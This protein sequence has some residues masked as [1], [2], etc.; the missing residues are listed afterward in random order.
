MAESSIN[1]GRKYTS[2]KAKAFC[3][4][5]VRLIEPSPLTSRYRHNQ[6][7]VGCWLL[8][9]LH[10]FLY[11]L[12]SLCSSGAFQL[13]LFRIEMADD[14][15]TDEGKVPIDTEQHTDI[16]AEA[17]I[18]R[19]QDD[20]SSLDATKPGGSNFG[21]RKI[22]YVAVS[23]LI[24]LLIAIPLAGSLCLAFHSSNPRRTPVIKPSPADQ[25][26]QS[27]AVQYSLSFPALY[28]QLA[29]TASL[30]CL[31]A[32]YTLGS[33]PC[34]D[35]IFDRSTDNCT[36]RPLGWDPL[37]VLPKVCEARCSTA[38][39]EAW[40]LLAMKCNST[41]DKFELNHYSGRFSP[42]HLETGPLAAV[43]MLLQ[44][45]LHQ[46]RPSPD[47]D[48]D[49]DYCPAELYDRF[50]IVDGINANQN[51]FN[52]IDMFISE[53]NK[54]RT[55]GAYKKTGHRGTNGYSYSYNF[56]V[57]EQNYGPGLGE[58]TC[59]SCMLNYLD[60]SIRAWTR[61]GITNP[62]TGKA[63]PLPEFIR[64][65]KKA[66]ERCSPTAKWDE[67]YQDAVASYQQ[68]DLLSEDWETAAD[69]SRDLAF[70]LLNGPSADDS[71]VRE[72]HAE[73]GRLHSPAFLENWKGSPP[74]SL[75]TLFDNKACLLGLELYY[76]SEKCYMHLTRDELAG[77][78]KTKKRHLR[79]SYC[80]PNCLESVF[81]NEAGLCASKE[82]LPA[83][84]QFHDSYVRA[85]RQRDVFCNALRP[86]SEYSDCAGALRNIGK[87]DWAL[88]GRPHTPALLAEVGNA[89][90]E[91]E[92]K[93]VLEELREALASDAHRLPYDGSVSREAFGLEREWT[94]ELGIGICAVCIWNM[95]AG[96]TF[97]NVLGYLRD[98][99]SASEYLDMV[100]RYHSV[101]TSRGATWL[102]GTPYG[103][104]PFLWR[105]KD[106]YGRVVRYVHGPERGVHRGF[107]FGLIE[108]TGNVTSPGRISG[109][110]GMF[111]G[112]RGR[113]TWS[114]QEEMLRLG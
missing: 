5:N 22:F 41:A 43:R 100:K 20:D 66:G 54:K 26:K 61:G 46:C 88:D 114:V 18:G 17:S 87:T 79:H 92:A 44:R 4:Y 108:A 107:L 85:L 64:R 103:D 12:R 68:A 2:A 50:A 28:P 32:W 59:G 102:G 31:T 10:V 42:D 89:L 51:L 30:D 101:C 105:V 104:D 94:G 47:G 7:D 48:S 29:R 63:V 112:R 91:L 3:S 33:V 38:L 27:H 110:C 109:R 6:D 34:H 96:P 58:T 13:L 55:D 49:Y 60:R 73:F 74:P 11:S 62:D 40:R 1:R 69:P 75:T 71:P 72:I 14:S 80:S 86:Q 23:I 8:D 35:A 83:V 37:Y 57:R 106:E 24:A 81:R 53:T 70:M 97:D 16:P 36:L 67:I 90:D 95:L 39:I 84:S 111:C 15:Y 93:P 45:N 76:T 98:A 25:F 65:V 52:G 82:L 113:W 77:L 56:M 19:Q 99:P 21:L 78:L 9:E